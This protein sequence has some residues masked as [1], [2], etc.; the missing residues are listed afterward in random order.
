MSPDCHPGATVATRT[1]RLMVKIGLAGERAV[2]KTSLLRRFE[3]DRFDEEY[4]ATLGARITRRDLTLDLPER[5]LQ[6]DLAMTIWDIMGERTVGQLLREAY[7]HGAKGILATC[8]IT[9]RESLDELRGWR[10]LVQRG[11]GEIPW[12]L[13]VNKVDRREEEGVYGEA[14]VEA[15][16]ASLDAPWLF[17]SAKTGAGVQE[18]FEALAR[19]VVEVARV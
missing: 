8:D 19:R 2:G 3:L 7:Y 1:V 11:A 6:V 16:A 4:V 15:L 12:V 17:T 5:A 13:A 9:R 14:E 10:D 18:A